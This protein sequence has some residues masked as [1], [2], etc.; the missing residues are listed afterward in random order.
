[1][2]YKIILLALFSTSLGFAQD[3]T[4]TS[5]TKNMSLGMQPGIEIF[6]PNVSEDNV[7]DA[8]KEVTKPYKGKTR[9]I[10]RSDEFY[11]DDATIEAI[12]NNTIDIH[13]V[14]AKGKDGFTYTAYFNLGGRFLDNAYSTEKYAYATEM[15]KKVALKASELRMSEVLKDEDKVLEKLKD[16][17]KDIEKDIEK[18]K[19]AIEDKTK[20]A[21]KKTSEIESQLKKIETLKAKNSSYMR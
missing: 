20:E 5:V 18:A 17:Q 21:Q 16:D 9:K 19:E 6:I 12:S 11:Q 3:F 13:Q 15:V 8:I 4:T 7:E 14:I 2:N 10:K 1:M